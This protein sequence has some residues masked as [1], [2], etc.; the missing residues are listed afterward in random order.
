MAVEDY[1]VRIAYDSNT[2]PDPSRRYT[3]AHVRASSYD[4]ALSQAKAQS[5]RYHTVASP[6]KINK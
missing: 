1:K 6:I 3:D 2:N 4:D 5:P